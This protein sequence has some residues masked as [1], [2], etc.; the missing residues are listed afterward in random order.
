VVLLVS[1]PLKGLEVAAALEEQMPVFLAPAI[2]QR[3]GKL[4]WTSPDRAHRPRRASARGI[5]PGRVVIWLQAER[6][7]L[8]A[9]PDGS[10]VALVSGEHPDSVVVD[11]A[12]AWSNRADYNQLI[13]YIEGVGASQVYVTGRFNETFA[14]AL[15]RRG[16][17]V[18]PLGP[19]KQLSL[20]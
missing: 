4:G 10:R 6:D 14:R 15:D 8:S 1:S 13:A 11:H 16:R 5:K 12:F 2:Y 18:L 17:R 20:L 19:P 7:R 9:L 3:A